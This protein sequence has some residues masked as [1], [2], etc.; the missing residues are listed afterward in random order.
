MQDGFGKTRG[1]SFT[2]FMTV[3]SEF[4]PLERPAGR[5][6]PEFVQK[7]SLAAGKDEAKTE[8]TPWTSH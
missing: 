2:D 5:L 4:I 6:L 7:P 1:R 8:G 3:D